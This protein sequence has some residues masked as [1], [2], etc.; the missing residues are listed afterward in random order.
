MASKVYN[1]LVASMPV[2]R[3]CRLLSNSQRLEDRGSLF[4]QL[5][6]YLSRLVQQNEE[7]L[8]KGGKVP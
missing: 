4:D 6:P 3:F 8:E 7:I 1:R 5:R 2:R